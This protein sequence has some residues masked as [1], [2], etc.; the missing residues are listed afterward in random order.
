MTYINS[1][2]GV[3]EV[4]TANPANIEHIL[5]TNFQN[6]PKGPDF[7]VGLISRLMDP[8]QVHQQHLLR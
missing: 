5:K 1:Y 6:Y 2:P 4:V 7:Q 3:T 8:P